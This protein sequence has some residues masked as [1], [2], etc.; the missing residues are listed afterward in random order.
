MSPWS[1]IFIFRVIVLQNIKWC[2]ED[3][4]GRGSGGDREGE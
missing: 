2:R 1:I 4:V 3:R